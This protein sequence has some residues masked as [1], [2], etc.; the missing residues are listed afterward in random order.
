ME[1]TDET[2]KELSNELNLFDMIAIG[3]HTTALNENTEALLAHTKALNAYVAVV[4]S[5]GTDPVFK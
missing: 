1:P 3:E 2:L 4:Q 5:V